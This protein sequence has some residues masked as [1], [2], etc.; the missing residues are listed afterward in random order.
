MQEPWGL[1]VVVPVVVIVA[2][3]AAAILTLVG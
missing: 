3:F 2:I 1:K